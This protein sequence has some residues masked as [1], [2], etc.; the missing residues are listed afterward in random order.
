MHVLPDDALVPFPT[1]GRVYQQALRVTHGDVTPLGRSRLDAIAS[2]LQH[3]A[4]CD[5]VD[6]GVAHQAAWI[7]R[8]TRIRIDRFPR[9]GETLELR[10][11]CSG[12][13]GLSAEWRTAIRGEHGAAV[14]AAT[15]WVSVDPETWRP[16]PNPDEMRAVF[17]PSTEGRRVR[18][19]LT[20]PPAPD[21]APVADWH[22]RTADLDIA[23]HV[24]NAAYWQAAEERLRDLHPDA[25]VEAEIEHHGAAGAGPAT[26]RRAGDRTWIDDADGQL[27]SSFLIRVLA[28]P[29]G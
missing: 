13:S 2:W 11:A 26:I 24:N 27:C 25:V 19:R 10:T 7:A 22:F 12:A 15:L 5:V 28:Q 14:E 4:F 9:F 29:A 21:D 16:R 18:V 3:L 20:H 1:V 17:G 8:R 23:G 6:A